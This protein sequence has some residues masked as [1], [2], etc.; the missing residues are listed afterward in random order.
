MFGSAIFGIV[1]ILFMIV[2]IPK[3]ADPNNSTT[4]VV[5]KITTIRTKTV[6]GLM[7]NRGLRK[8]KLK[9]RIQK[10]KSTRSFKRVLSS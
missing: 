6:E 9:R 2:T 7:V 3:I 8:R 4:K 10:P 5:L 1:A